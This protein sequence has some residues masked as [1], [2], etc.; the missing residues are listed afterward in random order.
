MPPKRRQ[1]LIMILFISLGSSVAV[2][3]ALY[4]LR[5]NINLYYT[6]TQI[7]KH[8]APIQHLLRIG[9]IVEEGSVHF[10]K[11]SVEVNFTVTDHKHAINVAYNGVLP[12]LFREGQGIIVEGQLDPNGNFIADQVLAKHGADY[13]PG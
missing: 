6:P 7:A 11:R 9:G 13:K 1:R 4:A 5:Q 10:S 2:G 8:Q 12:D 3:L